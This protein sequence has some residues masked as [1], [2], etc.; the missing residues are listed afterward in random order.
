MTFISATIVFLWGAGSLF[1]VAV[2]TS[3]VKSI[4]LKKPSII[5]GES[6]ILPTIAG[7][8]A[9]STKNINDIFSQTFVWPILGASFLLTMVSAS[10]NKQLHQLWIPHLAFYWFMLFIVLV[11][12]SKFDFDLSWWLVLIG[13]LLHQSLGI[14]FP[15]KFPEVKK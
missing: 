9:N 12:L 13:A 14:L 2:K 6:L 10:R 4:F 1:L 15:K 3:T 11:H 7:I 8:I 5:I